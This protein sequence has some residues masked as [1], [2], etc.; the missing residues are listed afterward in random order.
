MQRFLRTLVACALAASLT[1]AL[2]RAQVQN[3]T[4]TAPVT[5]DGP[6][7]DIVGLSGMSIA[8]DGTGGIVYQRLVSGVGHVFV[9]RLADGIF[10]PPQRVDASLG[11]G[12]SDQA[13]IAAGNNGVL[14]VAFI[15]GGSLYVVDRPSGD[16]AYAA[17]VRLASGAS[18][19][20]IQMSAFG[21]AYL[22]FA[23][24]GHGGSDVRAAYYYAGKW[25]LESASL[26]TSPGDDAGTG[27]GRPSVATAG[28]GI[29]TVAW[30]ENGHIYTRR[31][32]GTSP[33]IAFEQ[34]DVSNLGGSSEQSASQPQAGV[35]GNSS[36]VDVAF[37]ETFTNGSS[38]QTRV[39]LNRLQGSSYEGVTQ[40]DGLSTPGTESSQQPGVAVDE[41]GNGIVTS[42][43]QSSNELFA[44]VLGSN[45]AF[46]GS[47]RIDNASNA[48]TP[49]ATP[50]STGLNSLIVAWQQD[51]GSVAGT[52]IKTRFY[53]T[54]AGFLPEQTLSAPLLGSTDAADGL[55]AGGDGSG[56]AAVA[57]V[58]GTGGS[59]SIVAAFLYQAPEAP[60]PVA[61]FR[62][63]RSAHATLSWSPAEPWGPVRYTVTVDGSQVGTTDATSIA[64][65]N[66]LT[67]GPHPWTVTAVNPAGL[68]SGGRSA[69]IFVDTVAPA[70]AVRLSP[71]KRVGKPVVVHVSYTDVTGAVSP[72]DASGVASVVIRWGE[73]PKTQ[74]GRGLHRA[75]H[76]YAHAGRFLITIIVTD[77][78]GNRTTVQRTIAVKP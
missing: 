2:A 41:F 57:W 70:A 33:S 53:T 74:L 32:W 61:S 27:S 63:A 25:K 18:N 55:A 4:P 35:G 15:N 62:Y 68:S 50:A 58:Q 78:A 77:R 38:R 6:S 28:D 60:T 26:N 43:R 14:L 23:V 34:A 9:S 7:G 12:A 13:V 54:A 11:D 51:L 46:T 3:P 59:T 64:V 37:D 39:L 65:P 36:Y 21:K 1:P 69:E 73:G 22:A 5:V 30:G 76:I 19:P 10:Q 42:A 48:S 75:S 16:S 67:D 17:P 44:G 45:G 72:Q 40:P 47:F 56:D 52:E 71:S 20:S 49:D 29:A 24:G 8:R 31:V 66:T